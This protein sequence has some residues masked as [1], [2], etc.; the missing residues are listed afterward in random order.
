MLT[1]TQYYPDDNAITN[2]GDQQHAT[3]E[4]GPHRFLFPWYFVGPSGWWFKAISN[5][6]SV[7]WLATIVKWKKYTKNMYV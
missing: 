4:K 2:Y 7:K 3:K 1:L 5:K 6:I